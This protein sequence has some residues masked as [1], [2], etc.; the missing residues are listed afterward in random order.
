MA[1]V[2]RMESFIE[3]Y[4]IEIDDESRTVGDE[5]IKFKNVFG[6]MGR[7]KLRRTVELQENE[8]WVGKWSP[9]LRTGIDP[10]HFCYWDQA[11]APDIKGMYN[12]TLISKMNKLDDFV[13]PD[14]W[15]METPDNKCFVRRKKWTRHMVSLPPEQDDNHV[16]ELFVTAEWRSKAYLRCEHKL[17]NAALEDVQAIMNLQFIFE[18]RKL[19]EEE[20]AAPPTARFPN[21]QRVSMGLVKTPEFDCKIKTTGGN[22]LAIPG[23]GKAINKT[24]L[25][26]LVM[27]VFTPPMLLWDADSWRADARRREKAL[28][29][30]TEALR[31]KKGFLVVNAIEAFV[32]TGSSVAPTMSVDGGAG[33]HWKTGRKGKW[34]LHLFM[35]CEDG[36]RNSMAACSRWTTP[37]KISSKAPS[38]YWNERSTFVRDSGPC[39]LQV[40]VWNSTGESA[41]EELQDKWERIV[42]MRYSA[43]GE[44]EEGEEESQGRSSLATYNLTSKDSNLVVHLTLQHLRMRVQ[45]LPGIRVGTPLP[46]SPFFRQSGGC[47]LVAPLSFHRIPTWGKS[48]PEQVKMRVALCVRENSSETLEERTSSMVKKNSSSSG[49]NVEGSFFNPTWTTG[50]V[51]AFSHLTYPCSQLRLRVEML[52]FDSS[53]ELVSSSQIFLSL[54]HLVAVNQQLQ[55]P[56]PSPGGDAKEEGNREEDAFLFCSAAES[57]E[58][59]MHVDAR[60]KDWQ[61]QLVSL[62]VTYQPMASLSS[63]FCIRLLRLE[64]GNSRRDSDSDWQLTIAFGPEANLWRSKSKSRRFR[65]WTSGNPILHQ[66]KAM[67][68]GARFV[69][70]DLAGEVS[71]KDSAAFTSDE[72]IVFSLSHRGKPVADRLLKFAEFVAVCC[73]AGGHGSASSSLPS[74][75]LLCSS[76]SNPILVTLELPHSSNDLDGPIR[77]VF[78]AI[79][80]FGGGSY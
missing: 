62:L 12:E 35:P 27:N 50:E 61:R 70:F 16:Y 46:S 32:E 33:G 34:S 6:S 71:G 31:K 30:G 37:I 4:G 80:S 15:I 24:F 20:D 68:I 78:E 59:P 52:G 77:I 44:E 65:T 28:A 47:I 21:L 58:F 7:S 75:S 73:G 66:D 63:S 13:L 55:A 17:L 2:Q 8:R 53:E 54:S 60:L 76:L 18:F 57:I 43:A 29:M 74:A 19:N 41:K 48:A 49:S 5:P 11:N 14:G 3:E 22:I 1:C 69:S 67:W 72:W 40:E 51:M 42:T 45:P 10:S 56:A 26:S 25:G 64:L 79:F 36:K 39:E 9:P 38:S 23:L